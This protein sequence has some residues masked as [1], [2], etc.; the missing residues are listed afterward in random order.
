M[1]MRT[2]KEATGQEGWISSWP[3]LVLLW[4]LEMYGG[5]HISATEMEEVGL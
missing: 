5:F 3:V 1:K 4:D 2:K